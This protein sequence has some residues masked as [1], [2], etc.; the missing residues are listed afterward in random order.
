MDLMN[1]VGGMGNAHKGATG[2]YVVLP[3]IQFLIVLER[4]VESLLLCL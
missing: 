4:Q 1:E 2:V 3:P